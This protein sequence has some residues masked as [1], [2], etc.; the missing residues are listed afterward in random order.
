MHDMIRQGYE[1]LGYHHW[2]LVD[3]FEWDHGY[4]ERFGLVELDLATQARKPRP[5]AAFYAEIIRAN[6]LDEAMVNKYVPEALNEIFPADEP[7]T[8][9]DMSSLA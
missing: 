2:T 3:N 4:S 5:S 1:I 7:D 6:G 9:E 8:P